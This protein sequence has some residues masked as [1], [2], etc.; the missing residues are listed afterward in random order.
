MS[1]RER[2]SS[3]RCVLVNWLRPDTVRGSAWHQQ[4]GHQRGD[5]VG[6]ARGRTCDRSPM[7]LGVDERAVHRRRG[8][9]GRHGDRRPRRAEL[10]RRRRRCAGWTTGSTRRTADGA[11]S[12]CGPTATPG[13][14]ELLAEPTIPCWVDV[15]SPIPP[16]PGDGASHERPCSA[17]HARSSGSRTCWSSPRPA[18]PACSTSADD[19]CGRSSSS[20]RSASPAAARTSGTTSST[21]RATGTTRRSSSGRSPPGDP[22]HPAAR[23]VGVA[24]L[25]RRHRP[26]PPPAL[27]DRRPWSRSYVVMTL[28]YSVWSEAH[29][30]RRP[31]RRRRRF[32]AAR[33]R[34]R[35]RHRRA[36]EQVVRPV[37]LVRLAVH[38]H[39][40]ALRRAA[41][42]RRGRRTPRHAR[43]LRSGSCASCSPSA[44]R[45]RW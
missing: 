38:R 39:R 16:S 26:W 4:A 27:A 6:L 33:G 17:R 36:D 44:R 37:H 15:T 2:S 13:D 23:V 12:S 8:R 3:P 45:R 22:E 14:R 9:G 10:P 20:S 31:R 29:R 24:L 7:R 35:G 41:R 43:R 11:R 28:L 30:R 21:S 42:A 1:S 34:R 40:Q 19:S 5:R 18:P 32:R 25:T